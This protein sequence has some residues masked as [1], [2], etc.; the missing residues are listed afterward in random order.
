ME[1]VTAHLLEVLALICFEFIVVWSFVWSDEFEMLMDECRSFVDDISILSE[2]QV[3]SFALQGA[4]LGKVLIVG[5]HWEKVFMSCFAGCMQLE[6]F[7]IC[8]ISLVFLSIWKFSSFG[9]RLGL[10]V[11]KR[12]KRNR[13]QSKKRWSNI[14]RRKHL[15]RKLNNKG[16]LFLF[17][18]VSNGYGV[19]GMDAQQFGQFMQGFS[20]LLQR[21]AAFI[22]GMAGTMGS[23]ASS[24]TAEASAVTKSLESAARILKT[25]DF[26]DATDSSAWVTWRHSFMNWLGYADS[27][28]LESLRDIEKLA[29]SEEVETADWSQSDW[30]LA[31]KLY[32]VL[33]SYL[34]GSSRSGEDR[35]G[36]ALWKSLVDHYSPA[37]RQRALALRQS[38]RSRR[39]KLG[40]TKA[41]KSI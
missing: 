41:F 11:C 2:I 15:E 23:G 40:A 33:T 1:M 13:V 20:T 5:A 24:S 18:I 35:N 38:H 14:A 10:S 4:E 28:F 25:P 19:F 3:A 7:S 36:Y 34:R 17:L 27:R 37:T 26:F 8:A 16:H 30:D 31:H 12:R 32:A 6:P 9:M 29:P 22:Q 21:Q 39:T